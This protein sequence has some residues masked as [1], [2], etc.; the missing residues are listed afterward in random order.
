MTAVAQ[1]SNRVGTLTALR[2]AN[3]R[4]YFAGQLASTSGTWMQ[5]VAQGFLVFSITKSELWLGIVACAAG[6]PLVVLSP[7]A[8]VI[9][10]RFPRRQI[11]LYTQT[12]QMILAFT[13]SALTF[14][15]TVQVWHIV[16]LAFILGVTNALDTPARLGLIV[17]LVGRED[18]QSGIALGSIINS[19]SR[20]LGPTAAGVA[21]VLVGPVWCFFINGLSFLAVIVSLILMEVPFAI[22]QTTN[23]APLQQL[24]EGLSYARRDP[25]IAPI[26]LLTATVGFFIIPIIQIL[27]AFADVVLHSPKVGYAGVSVGEGVGAVLAGVAL[28]WTTYHL[29]RGRLVSLMIILSPCAILVLTH[30]TMVPL[31]AITSALMGFCTV[32]MMVTLNTLVQTA[33]PNEFRGRV[34]SLYSLAFFGLAPFGAL[35]LGFLANSIGG[36]TLSPFASVRLSLLLNATGTPTAMAIYAIIAG[37]VGTFILLRW[38]GVTRQV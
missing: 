27:P 13:L 20:V 29:K 18:L 7:F 5:N 1:A 22:K 37:V 28:G 15:G 31:A 14:T 9:V 3:F 38:P 35:F 19:G 26:L 36:N 32:S 17:E 25:I 11:M 2:H 24:K 30:M 16:I 23:S 10:E 12:V 8:G 6:L 33:T 21:L 4:L 34:L